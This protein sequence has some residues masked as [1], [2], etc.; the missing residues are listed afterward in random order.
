MKV[1]ENR[2]E[3]VAELFLLREIRSDGFTSCTNAV[4]SS[5]RQR[6]INY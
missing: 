3:A 2:V 5:A 6:H 1:A 4:Q